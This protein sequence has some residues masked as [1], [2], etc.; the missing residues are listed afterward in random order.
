MGKIKSKMIRRSAKA[1]VQRGISFTDKFDENKL[2]LGNTLPS[3]KIR[4]QIAG[5]LGKM[6][7]VEAIK[8]QNLQ[9]SLK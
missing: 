5:L 7:K 6:K 9:K 1:L 2:V 3:K 4:N 8:E